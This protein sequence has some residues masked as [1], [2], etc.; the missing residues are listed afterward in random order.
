MSHVIV[1]H[2]DRFSRDVDHTIR[3]SL[4]EAV[5]LNSHMRS[6]AIGK[7]I[8]KKHK[9]KD[10]KDIYYPSWYQTNDVTPFSLDTYTVL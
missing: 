10:N 3:I 7:K 6:D 5:Y 2:S 4:N 1:R 9:K 8:H